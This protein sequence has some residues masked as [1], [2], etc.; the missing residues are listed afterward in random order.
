MPGQDSEDLLFGISASSL[1]HALSPV[2]KTY[3]TDRDFSGDPLADEAGGLG[4]EGLLF[5][6]ASDSPND[7]DL[8]V[9]ANEVS[10]STSIW[11][12]TP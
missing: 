9:V 12:V 3:A 2:F 1:E 8:L 11:T 5:I 10:G 4:P 7:V 6:P